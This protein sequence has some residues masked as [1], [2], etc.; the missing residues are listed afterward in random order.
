VIVAVLPSA[1]GFSNPASVVQRLFE[2]ARDYQL[3][4]EDQLWALLDTDHWIEPNHTK[5]LLESLSD[6]RQRGVRVAMSNPC[7]DLWLLLHHEEVKRGTIFSDCAAVGMRIREIKGEFNKTN[8]KIEHYP[9]AQVIV[10]MTRARAL[11][12]KPNDA[13]ADFWPSASGTRVYLLINEL[14]RAGLWRETP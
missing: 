7:F 14:Q 9:S 5:G 10:A 2:Y 12:E 8:L 13:G 1:G 3:N 4:A 6:A 11:E